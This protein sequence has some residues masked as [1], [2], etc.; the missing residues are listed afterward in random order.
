MGKHGRL[1][2][3]LRDKND[4]ARLDLNNAGSVAWKKKDKRTIKTML[5]MLEHYETCLEKIEACA[6]EVKAKE[7]K[8]FEGKLTGMGNLTYEG[9]KP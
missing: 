2:E 1:L 5:S 7:I 6:V 4:E 8:K 3:F 9:P